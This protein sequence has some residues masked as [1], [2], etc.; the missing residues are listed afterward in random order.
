MHDYIANLYYIC[1]LGARIEFRVRSMSA[2]LKWVRA[3][4]MNGAAPSKCQ[5]LLIKY[6]KSGPVS[7]NGLIIWMDMNA[8][9]GQC[10]FLFPMRIV[11]DPRTG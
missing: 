4:E 5:K 2:Q 10:F 6:H 9:Q 8:Q 7:K 11:S 1:V 3:Y